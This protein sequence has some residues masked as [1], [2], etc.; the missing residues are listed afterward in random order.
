MRLLR[1]RM[2]R[3]ASVLGDIIALGGGP[4]AW[5]LR[6]ARKFVWRSVAR[7]LP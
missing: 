1:R 6:A 2:Y 7:M 3:G 5:V 4:P